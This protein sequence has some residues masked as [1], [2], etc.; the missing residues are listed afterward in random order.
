MRLTP[1][2]V[3]IGLRPNGN[4]DHPDWTRLPFIRKDA[5]TKAFGP[6]SW[7]Y[8]KAC[9]HQETRSDGSQWD[10]PHGMQWG[11][12]LVTKK[13][14][15]AVILEFPDTISRITEADFEDF[16][17]TKSRGHLPEFRYVKDALAS[18]KSE[19]DLL[20][21]LGRD[22]AEVDARIN[23]ALD[24]ADPTLGKNEQRDKNW[25]KF[26]AQHGITII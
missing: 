18:L 3:K 5:D 8:D 7:V 13:F 23:K 22:T 26:K 17:N 10:S 1:I 4:A 24:P 11:C 19:R 12:M 25:I 2:K 21:D 16:F 9:G 20:I 14:A 15:D 6:F